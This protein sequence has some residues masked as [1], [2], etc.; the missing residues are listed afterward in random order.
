MWCCYIV[1][2]YWKNRSCNMQVKLFIVTVVHLC[3]DENGPKIRERKRHRNLSA[4]T[5]RKRGKNTIDKSSNHVN[6]QSYIKQ[7]KEKQYTNTQQKLCLNEKWKKKKKCERKKTSKWNNWRWKRRKKGFSYELLNKCGARLAPD[8]GNV[9]NMNCRW[10]HDWQ[11][12]LNDFVIK[13]LW[14]FVSFFF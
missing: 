5:H 1:Q 6:E 2:A 9:T 8:N 14:W 11:V 13:R 3:T 10:K 4:H 7:M 12:H